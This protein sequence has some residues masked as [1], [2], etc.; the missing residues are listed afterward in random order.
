MIVIEEG[1]KRRV[2]LP[3]LDRS[4]LFEQPVEIQ[5]GAAVGERLDPLENQK[6]AKRI[7]I[8]DG[9]GQ[10]KISGGL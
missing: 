1:Q 3:E 2:A 10:V 9:S 4:T 6:S 7:I 8:E 5:F